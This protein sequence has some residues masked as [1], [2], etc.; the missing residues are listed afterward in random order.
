[1]TT[2]TIHG[3]SGDIWQRWPRV[4]LTGDEDGTNRK[5]PSRLMLGMLIVDNQCERLQTIRPHVDADG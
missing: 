3:S 5:A 1:M 2:S 4:V